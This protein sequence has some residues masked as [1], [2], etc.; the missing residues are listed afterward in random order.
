MR[1]AAIGFASR[2]WTVEVLTTC[3][4][5][6]YTWAN[7]LPEG[8][9]EED[10]LVVRRFPTVHT[11]SRAAQ[12]ADRL[13]MAKQMPSLDAQVSWLSFRFQVPGLFHQLLRYGDRFD[14]IV[15]SPYLFWTA[16]VCLPIV[17]D[18]AVI[19]PCLHDEW[20]A[21]LDVV[22]P[23]MTAPR[24]AWFNSEPE[25]QLA[26]RLGPVTP[27]H[28]VVGDGVRVPEAYNPKGFCERYGLRRPFLLYAGR[29]EPEKGWNRLLDLFSY[30]VKKYDL[31]LDLVTI[32]VGPV[33]PP[34][35]V[36]ERVVDLGFVSAE[37]RDSALAAASAYVQPSRLES[38]S[39][40]VMESWLAG[41]PVLAVA[42]SEVVAWHCQR[43]GG[44]LLF[45]DVD[46]FA[47]CVRRVCDD[48]AWAA[49][50]ARRGRE[51][52]VREYSWDAVLD[53][54]E[55]SLEALR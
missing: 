33:D 45:S 2:G 18:R 34:A 54:M 30:A 46:D 5:D 8:A 27:A 26:H 23:V 10:G 50:L 9:T 47:Q 42:D 53:R 13:I 43:S 40:T 44:G 35:E 11:G 20:Y 17:A 12:K 15:F 55:A 49:D 28:T 52:A 22:R 4:F 38:F 16:T 32:G 3:A 51:Y 31:D 39:L 37:E 29:R 14:A 19:K 36:S 1:E 25:H 41:T 24:L 21:R 6:H 7:D 48:P